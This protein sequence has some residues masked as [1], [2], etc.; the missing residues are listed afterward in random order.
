M[1]KLSYFEI[2]QDALITLNDPK[3]STRQELLKCATARHQDIDSKQ[4]LIRLKKVTSDPLNH[5][6]HPNKNNS[7]FRLEKNYKNK[8]ATRVKNGIPLSKIIKTKAMIKPKLIVK[9]AKKAKKQTKAKKEGKA[10]KPRAKTGGKPK[11]AK[12]AGAKTTKQAMQKK[13]K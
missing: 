2:I 3:G 10:R 5:I 9:K 11:A 4:F 6:E 8:V 7:R 1:P 12:N 13:A